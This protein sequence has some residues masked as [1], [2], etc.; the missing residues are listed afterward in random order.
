M[1]DNLARARAKLDGQRKAV[2]EHVE[3]WR[4]Y[5][6]PYEK[7]GGWKTVQ[8]AQRHIQKI[9]DDFPTLRDDSR[10]EDSWKPGDRL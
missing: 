2:R 7:D 10:A 4:R 9:K 6:E 8:N 1:A 3:K 5:S